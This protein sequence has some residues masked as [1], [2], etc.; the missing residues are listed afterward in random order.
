MF[1]IIVDLVGNDSDIDGDTL[2]IDSFTQPANGIV[3][4]N[5]D[6]TITYA[7]EAQGSLE[8]T[9]LPTRSPMETLPTRQPFRLTVNEVGGGTS[10]IGFAGTAID[11]T[12]VWKTINLPV[13]F[14]NPVVVAGGSTRDGGH[15]GIVRVRNVTV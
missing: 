4:D 9:R 11:V 15:Q 2:S 7:P 3:T 8:V 14:T 1:P 6:G 10:E 5:G 12:H 13:S